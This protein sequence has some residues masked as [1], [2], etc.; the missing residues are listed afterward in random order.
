MKEYKEGNISKNYHSFLNNCIENHIKPYF[1][2]I[3]LKS[4]S[5]E[6]YQKFINHLFREKKL[7]RNT[8]LKIHNAIYNC[9]K[10]AKK[11][12]R[13]SDNPCVDVV[14]RN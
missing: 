5:H 7:A 14:M 8:I 9:M 6:T 11:N 1:K 13:I 10:Q 12:K 3:P 2:N 4:I